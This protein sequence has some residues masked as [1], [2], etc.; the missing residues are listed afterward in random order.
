MLLL[1]DAKTLLCQYAQGGMYE[2]DPRL[3][4]EINRAVQT[5]W[6]KAEFP[7]TI[8]CV[9]MCAYNGCLTLPP[10][11]EKVLRYRID[12]TLARVFD[13]WYEFLEAGLQ[14]EDEMIKPDMIDRGVHPTQYELTTPMRLG[15]ISDRTE[16]PD[17]KIIIRGLDE[18]GRDIR[19]GNGH[20]GEEVT[21]KSDTLTV[22]RHTFA[23]VTAIS[24]PLTNGFVSLSGL[25]FDADGDEM[26]RV[27]LSI[28][29]PNERTPD[30]RRYEFPHNTCCDDHLYSVHALVRMRY[31]QALDDTDV[32]PIDNIPALAFMMQ[33]NRFYDASDE[34]RGDKYEQLAEKRLLEGSRANDTDDVSIDFDIAVGGLGGFGSV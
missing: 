1:G 6:N 22:T 24:K 28:Y 25:S 33:A 15:I 29:H 19:D 14:S 31:V 21:L 20:W 12:G 4:G 9:R 18:E 11:I 32:V 5:L 17:T 23:E 7:D 30:Y 16:L 34:A 8:R 26:T 2:D 27:H 3:P 13:K 10:D